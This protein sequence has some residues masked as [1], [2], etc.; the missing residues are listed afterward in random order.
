MYIDVRIS[1]SY[2]ELHIV[3]VCVYARRNESGDG[4]ANTL[5]VGGWRVVVG[6]R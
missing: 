6:D 4:R 3:R 1:Y 5:S 2:F